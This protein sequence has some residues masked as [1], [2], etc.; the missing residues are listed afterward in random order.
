MNRRSLFDTAFCAALLTITLLAV[1]TPS[2]AQNAPPRSG[3]DGRETP[4]LPEW[5]RL[6]QAQRDALLAMVRE[7]WNSNPQQRAR[8]MRQAEH[9]RQLTPEQRKRAQQGRHLWQQMSPEERKRA[10]AA[11][12][13]SK[14][15][16][17]EERAALRDKL[18]AMT[19]EQRREWLRK[20]RQAPDSQR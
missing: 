13:H 10:R 19:P 15:L 3:A 4:Q 16:S 6:S 14:H 2:I 1:A 12:E 5:D 18:R 8:L 9:W 7:Q 17:P 20:Y 11:F